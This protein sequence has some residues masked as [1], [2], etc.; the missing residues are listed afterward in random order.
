MAWAA[1]LARDAA[2]AARHGE[3]RALERVQERAGLLRMHRRPEN[4][5]TIR[6]NTQKHFK[7][8]PKYIKNT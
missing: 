7:N 6:Q 3:V 1:G 2:R 4:T 8:T 5:S